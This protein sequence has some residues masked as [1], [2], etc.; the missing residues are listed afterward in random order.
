M[1]ADAAIADFLTAHA[2]AWAAG[3]AD[4]IAEA[5]GLPQMIASAD[6]TVFLEED[7]ELTAWINARLARWTELGV[8]G[9]AVTVEAVEGLPDDA[10]R[11]SSRWRLAGAGGVE[12]RSFTAVDTLAADDGDWYYVVTDLAGEDAAEAGSS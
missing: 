8:T 7:D 9:V 3:D 6:G 2:A 10:A 11:V 12:V 4:T 5:M 1:T